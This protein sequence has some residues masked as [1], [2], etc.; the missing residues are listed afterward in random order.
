MLN[1][2]SLPPQLILQ[3]MTRHDRSVK[4]VHRAFDVIEGLKSLNE[5]G[6]TELAAEINL[7]ASTVHNYLTT[8][9]ERQYVVKQGDDYRLAT[10]FVHL[11]DFTKQ[12]HELFRVGRQNVRRL[13]DETG[14][15]VNL[16]IEEY[17]RGIYLMCEVGDEGLSN[18]SYV[19]R[20]EYLHST[21]A[22]KAILMELGDD[23]FDSV[24]DEHGLPALT[25][26]TITDREVLEEELERSYSRGYTI[27][28]QEN[29]DGIR[30]IGASVE[31][32]DGTYG[33][34]SLSGPVN[35]MPD[36]RF[37]NELPGLVHDTARSI[38]IELTN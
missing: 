37:Q 29:T 20:R 35:H 23:R 32:R 2:L 28:D 30:A 12:D 19:R 16:V 8:L 22:G 1:Y 31:R 7:P 9:R 34:V 6:V 26:A 4:S 13:A 3:Q 15:T 10:R 27:N 25:P 14:D 24:I 38:E 11:G 33:A 36:D 21:A 5:A 17:G 18:Y